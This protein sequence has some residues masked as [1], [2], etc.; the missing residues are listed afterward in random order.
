MFKKFYQRLREFMLPITGGIRATNMETLL[1]D[2]PALDITLEDWQK[3]PAAG[4]MWDLLTVCI[5][6]KQRNVLTCFEIGTGH[7]R[8]THHLAMNTPTEAKI[9]TLDI[10]TIDTDPTMGSIFR[11]Q[12]TE[13][14]ITQ[15]AG[16]SA[17]FDFT[18][19]ASRMD[20]VIV[21]GGHDQAV[22]ERDTDTAFEL[23]KPGGLI[24]WD[25]FIPGWSGVIRALRGHRRAKDLRRI[26]GTK[27]VV[28]DDRAAKVV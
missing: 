28:Y 19:Y 22:V 7:G 9:Y 17:T 2:A 10:N 6:A 23:V 3:C 26:A 14:K 25:D 20:F 24:L 16:D 12:P 13:A 15:L 1:G 18:P 8:S 21:D 27:W 4:S 11:G 5:L